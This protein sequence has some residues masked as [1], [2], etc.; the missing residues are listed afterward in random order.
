[1][2]LALDDVGGLEWVDAPP[3]VVG[4]LGEWA[5]FQMNQT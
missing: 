3:H 4:T 5:V 1:M 2:G